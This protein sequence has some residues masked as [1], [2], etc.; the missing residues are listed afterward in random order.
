MPTQRELEEMEQDYLQMEREQV[1]SICREVM[2]EELFEAEMA[3]EELRLLKQGV[4]VV[5]PTDVDHAR[6][7]FK[8]ATFYLCQHD[9]NFTLKME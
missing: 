6:A 7:M 5:L 4:T 1:E 8:V 2:K 9:K 3:K